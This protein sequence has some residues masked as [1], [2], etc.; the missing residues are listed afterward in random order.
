[1]TSVIKSIR[2]FDEDSILADEWKTCSQF[3]KTRNKYTH[4]KKC[5]STVEEHKTF[6]QETDQVLKAIMKIRNNVQLGSSDQKK[7]L[8]Y[9]TK[10]E[11]FLNDTEQNTII[12][13]KSIFNI[14][15]FLTLPLTVPYVL[16][17]I[18]YVFN[19]L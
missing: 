16:N 12:H 9:K 1:M 3:Q 7:F 18:E 17:K 10:I 14:L 4:S 6:L 13:F 19:N 5:G 11:K 15:V 2:W 8:K